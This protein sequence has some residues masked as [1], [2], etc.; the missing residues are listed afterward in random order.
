MVDTGPGQSGSALQI[1]VKDENGESESYEDIG[2]HSMNLGNENCNSGGVITRPVQK[3][4]ED[5]IEKTYKI[6]P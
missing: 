6:H 5:T 3:W 1:V 2:V 4:M